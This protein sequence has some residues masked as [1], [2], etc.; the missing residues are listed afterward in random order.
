MLV[1]VLEGCLGLGKG[2][3]C[4]VIIALFHCLKV[5]KGLEIVFFTCIEKRSLCLQN[6]GKSI[7]KSL[8]VVFR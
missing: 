8:F 6:V 1:E 5:V 4:R 2:M 3:D 7:S